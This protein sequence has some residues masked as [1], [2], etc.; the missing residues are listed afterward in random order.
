MSARKN[1]EARGAARSVVLKGESVKERLRTMP[2]NDAP[3]SCKIRSEVRH[4]VYNY[5][6]RGYELNPGAFWNGTPAK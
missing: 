2:T 6:P 5:R 4:T 3:Q 1:N